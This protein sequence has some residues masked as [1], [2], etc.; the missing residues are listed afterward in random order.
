MTI[1]YVGLRSKTSALYRLREN[2]HEVID[3]VVQ[4]RFPLQYVQISTGFLKRW[5]DVGSSRRKAQEYFQ[6]QD[7]VKEISNEATARER[8]LDDSDYLRD[9]MRFQYGG[10]DQS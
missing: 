3:Y 1:V 4:F 2:R 8:H 10:R 6:N 7:Q 5:L 9:E